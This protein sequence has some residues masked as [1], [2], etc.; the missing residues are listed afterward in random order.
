MPDKTAEFL[1]FHAIN[2]FMRDD[3]RL[4]VIRSTLNS[5]PGLPDRFRKPIDRLTREHV[6]VTGFRNSV[7]APV[8]VKAPA[9]ADGFETSPD[10]VAAILAAW[11]EAHLELR[12]RVF[13]L[14]ASRG[15]ELLPADADRTRLPGFLTQWPRGQ[16]FDVLN[17]AYQE[18]HPDDPAT[19][20]EVSLMVVWLGGRL[21]YH[22]ESEDEPDGGAGEAAPTS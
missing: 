21:P 15:W 13:E 8:P 3:F 11:S 18:A 19:T 10:L 1:P 7:Q 9:M 16:D 12:T 20:D 2:Q 5:L 6:R 22:V 14:L 4:A 17:Q